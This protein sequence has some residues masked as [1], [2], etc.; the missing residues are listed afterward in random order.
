[1]RSLDLTPISQAISYTLSQAKSLGQSVVL[2]YSWDY[3]ESEQTSADALLA[4]AGVGEYKFYWQQQSLTLAAIGVVAQLELTP[5]LNRFE[6]AQLFCQNYLNHSVTRG[7]TCLGYIPTYALGGFAFHDHSQNSWQG[8]PN[9]RLFIPQWLIQ[10]QD[11]SPLVITL[12]CCIYPH[13]DFHKLEKLICQRVLE[14]PNLGESDT[15][16]NNHQPNSNSDQ[17]PVQS[18]EEVT[19]DRPWTEIVEQAVNL[20]KKG[21]LEKIVLARAL[22][23]HSLAHPI[24]V[25]NSLRC[26]YPECISFLLNFGMTSF[27]GATPEILLQFQGDDFGNLQLKSDA[28]AGSTRRGLSTSEDILLGNLLL[29]SLKDRYEHEIVIRS[30]CDRLQNLGVDLQPLSPPQLKRLRNVQHLYTEI[31]GKLADCP[32]L[33]SFEIL[34]QLHPTAAVG[35]EPQDISVQLIQA[36]EACDRG[37]YAAPIG[38]VNSNGAGVFAVGIRSGYINGE[39]ARIYA[40]AGIVADSDIASELGETAIKF[41]ALLRALKFS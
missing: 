13:D 29:A 36:S 39:T 21:K 24:E 17:N 41:E 10:K 20:I 7:E 37:W 4:M 33:K 15:S 31:K 2:S 16:A 11:N 35:G 27:V 9:A 40:G 23:V 25:L 8:F 3:G 22:D 14:F 32:W 19:G 12:N 26:S 28:I 6:A 5:N 18:L 1:M 30:I 38:W 34:G